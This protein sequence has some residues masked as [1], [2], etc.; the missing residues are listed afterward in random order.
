MNREDFPMLE[1]GYIYFDN[2]ATTFKPKKVI[3][4]IVDYYSEYTANAHRGDYDLSHKVDTEYE[5]TRE[6]VRKFINARDRDEIIFTSGTTESMNMIVFSFF[7]YYLHKD[8]EVLITKTEHASNVLPWYELEKEIGIVVKFIPLNKNHEV[9]LEA[10]KSVVTEKT[11]VVS[12]ASI[13]N[14]I[15]D[16][17]PILEISKFVHN[18]DIMLVV[19]GAQ[20]VPHIKTDV[21]RDNI[22]F[23]AFSAHKMLGPTGVGVLYGKKKYL[24]MMHPFKYGGGM[25]NIFSS[26]KEIE[27]KEVPLK[28]EAGTENIAGVLGLKEAILYLENIGMDKIHEYEL[29]LK[30]YLVEKLKKIDNITVYNENSE[31]GIVTFNINK[32]FAEDASKYLNHYKICVRAGNHCSKMVKDEI[33][34]KNT[35]RISLYLYNTK[36]EIDKLIDVLENS[37]DIYDI[38]L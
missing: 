23:L 9:E 21:I 26:T 16:I 17:R 5:N 22:D 34:V 19:D 30:K 25:N 35:C 33:E 28:L 38:I 20:G 7:K 8:D 18:N 15:G 36:K 31:A 29:E 27:Y 4:K 24:E 13:T 1:K 6:V 11:K 37:K 32:I 14:V 3:D 12:I 2:G 10:L